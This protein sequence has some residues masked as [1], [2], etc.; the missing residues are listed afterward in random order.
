MKSE[1]IVKTLFGNM[2]EVPV[3]PSFNEAVPTRYRCPK[4]LYKWSGRPRPESETPYV[5]KSLLS[6]GTDGIPPTEYICP[7]CR[8][9]WNGKPSDNLEALGIPGNTRLVKPILK[10]SYYVPLMKETRKLPYNGMVVASTFSGCGGSSL[11]WRMAGFRVAW[12]SEFVPAAQDS[13][14]ANF[15]KTILDLRD[16]REVTPQDVLKALKMRKGQLDVLDGSPPC[17]AFSTAG[18]REKNWGKDKQYEHG[19]KQKNEDM[20]FEYVRLLKGLMPKV[21][22]AEN[23]SGLVKGTAKGYFQLILSE[24]KSAG[25]NVAVKV[26]DAQWLG[27]PQS[28][29]RVIFIGV[30]SDLGVLPTHPTALPYRYSVRDAIPW[31]TGAGYARGD[32]KTESNWKPHN[33]TYDIDIDV[34]GSI[35]VTLVDAERFYVIHNTRGNPLFSR[36]DVTN[37]PCPAITI[38]DQNSRNSS[39][40]QVLKIRTIEPETDISGYQIAEEWDK[41]KPGEQSERYFSLQKAHP[42]KPCPAI[43]TPPGGSTRAASVCHPFERRKFTIAELKRICAFPDDFILTGTYAQQWARLGNAVPPLMMRAIAETVRDE[44]FKKIK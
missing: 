29:Q 14:R 28:R 4:C 20:F 1:R 13:Y 18:R 39:H 27:V 9:E 31:I 36:G 33:V 35:P 25:Y 26:L 41:L 22:V 37:K 3:F 10:P 43:L 2:V 30:R 17:Q 21:F 12:A 6:T 15:L 8:Y 19:A 23:V 38:G 44:I 7:K 34:V 40:F 5:K 24:L 32:A 11:G 16:V 42:E